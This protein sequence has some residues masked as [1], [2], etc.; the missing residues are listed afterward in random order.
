MK[1]NKGFTL[2][3][4]LAVIVILAVIAL[5]ATPMILN[6]VETAREGA[7]KSSVLG[8]VDAVEKQIM[9]NQVDNEEGNE[10]ADG[11]YTIEANGA[12]KSTATGAT[13]IPVDV[14]GEAPK[15]PENGT[16]TITNGEIT[17]TTFEMGKYTIDYANG[18]ATKHNAG[19]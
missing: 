16:M 4:L 15:L 8:Y 2:I 19:E 10:I 13:A 6:V 5:I 9:I 3:E 18:K 17:A 12:I 14:K 1:S 11:T 7:A